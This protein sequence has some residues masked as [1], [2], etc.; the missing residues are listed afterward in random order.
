MTGKNNVK[1]TN[2]KKGGILNFFKELKGEVKKITWPTKDETKNAFIVV[3]IFSLVYMILIGGL[4]YI[5]RSFFEL[6]LN[7]K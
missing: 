6:I 2:A 4:D 5:F 7:I 1:S 3:A